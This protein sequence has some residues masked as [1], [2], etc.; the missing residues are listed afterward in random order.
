MF[1]KLT[2]NPRLRSA[3]RKMG[4]LTVLKKIVAKHSSSY[5]KHFDKALFESIH[6]GDVVWDVGANVGYYTCKFAHAVG[7]NGQVVAFEPVK[8][9]YNR[10]VEAC[11]KEKLLNILP[12]QCALGHC[13]DKFSIFLTNNDP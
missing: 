2:S 1:S 7:D 3:M 11:K 4:I 6:K 9:T 8:N 5:E 13:E 12:I 10:M